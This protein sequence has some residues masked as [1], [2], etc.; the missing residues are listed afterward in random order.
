MSEE[1]NDNVLLMRRA[2]F[3]QQVSQFMNSDIG[4]YMM[5]RVE[6]EVKEAFEGLKN[7]DP[8]D[9]KLVQSHQNKVWKAETIKGW[10]EDAVCD[11]LAAMNVINEE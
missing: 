11:G 7:C 10:L 4:R 5:D 3:G 9:G 2:I 8:K 6:A 1:Q